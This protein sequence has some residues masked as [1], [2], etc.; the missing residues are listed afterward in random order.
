MKGFKANQ[1]P[2][3]RALRGPDRR[4][5]SVA[6]QFENRPFW[7]SDNHHELSTKWPKLAPDLHLRD[8]S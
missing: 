5:T 7:A 4:G 2:R 1:R 6:H 3:K 8:F